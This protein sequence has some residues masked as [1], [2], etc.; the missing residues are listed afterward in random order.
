MEISG[1][2]QMYKWVSDL[3]PLNRSLTGDG[4]RSTLKYLKGELPDLEVFEVPSGTRAFD[5]TIPRE[6]KINQAWIANLDGEKIV[7]LANSNLHVMG[8][9]VSVDKVVSRSELEPHLYSIPEQPNAIPYVTSYYK[10]NFGF[11]LTQTQ[12]DSLGEGPF[13]I[14]IDSLHFDGNLTYAELLIPGET[15]K[16]IFFSTYVC[17]PSMAN[18]ELSGPVVAMALAKYIERL[19]SRRFTYRFLFTVETI[20][21]ILYI[22][23]HLER[24]KRDILCGWVLTCIGDNRTYSYVPTRDGNTL[25]DSISN[26]VLKD[27]N[28]EYIKYTWLDRGSDERQYNSPGIDLPI[29]SL[30]R[31]KYGEYAEYHTSLDNLDFVSPEGLAGGLK[32]LTMAVDILETNDFWKVNVL[33]EPQ[34]GKRGLYPNTSTKSSASQVRNRMN[35]ISFLDG[36]FDLLS[37]ANK[38]NISYQQVHEIV[39]ELHTVGLVEK[40]KNTSS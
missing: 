19:T 36:K 16:E 26:Q 39:K 11:C 9:S 25:T 31:S 18:N 35:V 17:H 22:S 28:S 13:H 7:D 23:E 27:L 14:F 5:W 1:G 37:I 6:W 3:F 21:S 4:V 32:M 8:Y 29:A 33:G 2:D 12:R 24:M 30:M 15:D 10:E 38:C 20:G 40:F 34:L